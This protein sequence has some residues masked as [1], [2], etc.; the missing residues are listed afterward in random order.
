MRC[1]SVLGST[2]SIGTN[3]LRVAA[4]FPDRF[5]IVGLAGG[6]N[7]SLLAEQVEALQPGVV[8]S[9]DED[10]SRELQEILR[11]RGYPLAR[12]RFVHGEAGNIEV[13]C[14]PET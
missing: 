14:Y 7:V 4:G 1:I 11:H 5:R 10:T 13:S 3:T 6:R 8:S 12:T 9:L 2:G